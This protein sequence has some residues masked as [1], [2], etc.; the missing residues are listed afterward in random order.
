LSA[1]QAS[2]EDAKSIAN[3]RYIIDSVFEHYAVGEAYK[4]KLKLAGNR[5]FYS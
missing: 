4:A 2:I 5:I 1:C 3:C